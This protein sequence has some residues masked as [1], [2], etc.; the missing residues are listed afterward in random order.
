MLACYMA[1]H[2]YIAFA[3]MP[4]SFLT[5]TINGNNCFCCDII[6]YNFDPLIDVLI[7]QIPI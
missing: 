5:L 7:L 3:R 1:H 4:K 6:I 2:A